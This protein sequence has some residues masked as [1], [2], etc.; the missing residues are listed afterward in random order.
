MTR[1]HPQA[2]YYCLKKSLQQEWDFVKRDTQGLGEE[3]RPVE[4]ALP[5]ELLIFLFLGTEYHMPEWTITG[6]PVKHAGIK[7]LDM[8]QTAQGN[9]TVLCV[10]TV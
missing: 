5:R 6:F 1:N 7:I 2:A 8:T 3:F 9:W 10:V 4:K